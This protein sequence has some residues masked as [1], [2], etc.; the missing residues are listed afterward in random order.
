MPYK[1]PADKKANDARRAAAILADPVQRE[2]RNARHCK[3]YARL[4][5][6]SSWCRKR[7]EDSHRRNQTKYYADVAA[8]RKLVR[9][10]LSQMRV[11][12]TGNING[13]T[14]AYRQQHRKQINASTKA[15][16]VAHPERAKAYR[17]AAHLQA[18]YKM[19]HKTYEEMFNAQGGVCA[20]CGQPETSKRLGVIRHMHVDH[21]H[22]TGKVRALL[23]HRCNSALGLLKDDRTLVAN[24]LLYI[25]KYQPV[26]RRRIQTV[27]T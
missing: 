7:A 8:S 18:K 19:T 10:R 5:K 4:K 14:K 24:L 1:N 17:R 26:T 2:R 21:D 25:S 9:E 3:N 23:C 20:A 6:N 16:L 12:N 27:G 13:K 11:A 15:W 22:A